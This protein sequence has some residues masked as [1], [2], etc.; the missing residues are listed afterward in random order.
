MV[1][2]KYFL[3]LKAVKFS[4]LEAFQ[5]IDDGIYGGKESAICF[6]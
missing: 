1:P 3:S 5:T 2:Y 6:C 4:I